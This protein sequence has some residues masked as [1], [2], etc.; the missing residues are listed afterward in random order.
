LSPT[1]YHLLVS[2]RV[3]GVYFRQSAKQEADRLGLNGWVRNL[4]DGRVE[5]V[6]EGQEPLV[7]EWLAWAHK[8]PPGATVEDIEISEEAPV[9]E[10]GFK[11]LP[12]HS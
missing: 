1:R 2:G 11:V 3:Q 12:T 9:G 10:A 6:V 4:S 5:A 8:G 7:A